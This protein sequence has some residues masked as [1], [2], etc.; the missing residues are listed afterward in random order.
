MTGLIA[1]FLMIIGEFRGEEYKEYY[2]ID[3]DNVCE[4]I[5][6]ILLGYVSLITVIVVFIYLEVKD[7]LERNEVPKKFA[8]FLFKIANIGVKDDKKDE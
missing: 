5:E 8:K 7:I 1:A 2:E 3:M 6:C 4:I